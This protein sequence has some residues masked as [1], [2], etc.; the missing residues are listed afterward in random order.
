MDATKNA[1]YNQGGNV[2]ILTAK[3]LADYKNNNSKSKKFKVNQFYNLNLLQ[4]AVTQ[5]FKKLAK[6][7][8]TMET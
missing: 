6:K 2:P 1:K 5:S 7:I 4:F 3:V 8:A